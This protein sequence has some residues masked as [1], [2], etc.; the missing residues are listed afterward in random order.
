MGSG[1]GR[2]GRQW[3]LGG[4]CSLS[5][6]IALAGCAGG[7]SVLRPLPDVPSTIDVGA[8]L[9]VAVDAITAPPESGPPELT[10]D[11]VELLNRFYTAMWVQV[12]NG[13]SAAMTVE[14][15][16]AV[17][18]DRTGTP[19]VALDRTQRMRAL[20]WR[21]WSWSA[22]VAGWTSA[23]RLTQL[24]AK[25][26]RLQFAPGPLPAG[27]TRRGVLVFNRIPAPVCERAELEWRMERDDHAPASSPQ[28]VVRV[29]LGC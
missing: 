22:W 26:D 16:E 15:G 8:G 13:T 9:R 5:V 4:V 23:D 18:F 14:P 29:M 24:T 6:G 10:A 3:L 2:S 20:R 27:E 1:A 7:R 11:D 28:P 12:S 19:W 17:L 21:P 25:L